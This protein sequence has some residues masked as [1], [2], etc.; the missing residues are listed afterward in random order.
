MN[1]LRFLTSIML[2]AVLAGCQLTPGSQQAPDRY[3]LVLADSESGSA[4]EQVAWSGEH[5]VLFVDR[6][7]VAPGYDT[8]RIAYQTTP[9]QLR[10]YRDS[11]WTDT[12][13]RMLEPALIAALEDT[14]LFR[15]VIGRPSTLAADY[16]LSTDLLHLVQRFDADQQN[17]ATLLRLRLRLLDLD[18]ER[19]VDTATVEV[20][21]TA[22]SAD[23]AGGVAAANRALKQAAQQVRDFTARALAN[24]GSDSTEPAVFHYRS[25]S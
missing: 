5:G 1:H 25:G 20:S 16:R 6:P 15:A 12:P 13:D 10:Y 19:I 17:S 21:I 8:S 23:A 24:E 4:S 9:Y 3:Q 2:L 7:R 11:R 18:Q 14:G 22:P